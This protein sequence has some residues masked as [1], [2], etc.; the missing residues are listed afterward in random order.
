MATVKLN[1]VVERVRGRIGDLVFKKFF[2]SMYVARTPNTDGRE[3]S[4][5]QRAH[6]EKFRQAAMFGKAAMADPQVRALYAG[7]AKQRKQPVFSL[8]IADYF[9]PPSVDEIDLSEYAGQAGNTISIRA[10]DD[11]GVVGVDVTISDEAG[12]ALE[13]GPANVSTT[14]PGR[15][16][17]TSTTSIQPGTHVHVVATATDRPGNKATKTESL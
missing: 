16:L 15:W 9:N 5:A 13:Q 17:Y 1:P 10:S 11:V 2:G 6:L 4:A 14:E 12:L 3:P 8:M 7:A